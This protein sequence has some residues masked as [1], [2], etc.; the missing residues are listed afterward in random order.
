MSSYVSH[1]I[2]LNGISHRHLARRLRH[3]R[4]T[5]LPLLRQRANATLLYGRRYATSEHEQ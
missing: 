4:H 1:F 5:P 2:T 3:C